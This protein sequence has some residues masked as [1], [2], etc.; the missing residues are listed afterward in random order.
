MRLKGTRPL[1]PRPRVMT[2]LGDAPVVLLEAPG[3]YGKSTT[4]RQLAVALD[5]PLVRAVLPEAAGP[6]VFLGVLAQAFRRAGLP[7]LAETVD[8]D[9]PEGTLERLAARL[10]ASDGLVLAVDDAQRAPAATAA[11]L[12]RLAQTIP[13]H[14]R[15]VIAGRRLDRELAGLVDRIDAVALGADALRLDA[16]E[17]AAVLGADLTAEADRDQVAAITE[18]TGGWPAA[19]ALSSA[20]PDHDQAAARMPAAPSQVLRALVEDLLDAAGPDDAALIARLAAL[21]LLSSSVAA[22]LGGPGTLD[23]LLDLGLPVRFRPDGWGELPDPVRELL[24]AGTPD[25]DITRAAARLYAA[26][27]ALAEAAGLLHRA[28]DADGLAGL[29]ASV[30]RESLVAGGLPHLAA[31]AA[32]LPDP[33]LA[34]H[35]GLVVRL[36]QAAERRG[37]LREEWVTRALRL[38]PVASAERRAIDVEHALDLARGGDLDGGIAL[39]RAT[40][41]ATL[42]GDAATLGRAHYVHGLLRLVADPA[43]SAAATAEEMEIAVGLFQAAGERAWE[44]DAW[45]VLGSG[46]HGSMGR[47]DSAIDCLERAL[48]LRAA[49]DAVRA[50]TLTYHAEMLTHRGRLDDAAVAVRE[51]EGIGRRSGDRRAIAYAAWSAARLACERRDLAG[52]RAALALAEAN[53]EGW[54]DQ[55]AGI[56][57]LADGADMLAA[58]GDVDG[59]RMLIARVE[60]RGRAVQREDAALVAS[61]RLAATSD[62]PAAALSLIDRLEAS[63]LA[64]PRDRWLAWLLRAVALVRAGRPNEAEP[65]LEQA[66][67]VVADQGDPDRLDRREPELLALTTPGSAPVEAPPAEVVVVL[68][69]RFAVERGGADVSPPP[70]RSATL[71]KLVALRGMVTVDEAVEALWDDAVED[72][73]R[74]RLR[75][76][77]NRVRAACG[78]VIVRREEALA[79]APGVIVDAGRFEEEAGVALRAPT[80]ARVGLARTALARAR[81]ELLPGDRYVDWA[82]VPRERITRRHLALLDLVADDAIA[83]ADLD[84]ANRLLD[85]AIAIEPLEEERHVRLVRALLRQGRSAAARRVADRALALCAE[86]DVEPGDDLARFLRDLARQG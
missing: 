73:G 15:L 20:L 44:A 62:D 7:A 54:F 42:P 18:T 35:P 79:L 46:C 1:V 72:V 4:A 31:M 55:L 32:G 67:R 34:A 63:A 16:A 78:E 5:R 69:G 12:A 27:D 61:A 3:G 86:L 30:G 81:G 64:V 10:V 60:A 80:D 26:R 77:L 28:G 51:A 25:L 83:R 40:I 17:V 13:S 57:F 38:L 47:L 2:L 24:P 11:W 85:E 45:Q 52:V 49:R 23:R 9:D 68:L 6:A 70:G 56:E 71:V 33:V 76:V 41:E 58:M 82:S 65:W 19:V 75:N 74:A 84:E 22:L 36:A 39:V 48:A 43:A 50:T 21:P 8:I 37:R 53:P 59:A 66:R 29:L 14:V